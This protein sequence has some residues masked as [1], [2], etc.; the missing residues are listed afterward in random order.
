VIAAK[1]IVFDLDGVLADS[2]ALVDRAWET[3]AARHGVDPDRAVAIGRGRRA[4]EAIRIL[5]PHVD[6]SEG[7]IEMETL[8]EL[9]IESVVPIHGAPQFVQ[10]AI[11]AGTPWAVATSGTRRIAMPRLRRACIPEP[12]VLV[13]A[14]DITHGKPHPEPYEKAADALGFPPWECVV[15]E[16][17]PAGMLAARRSGAKVIGIGG[18]NEHT[19]A[20]CDEAALDFEDVAIEDG[21]PPHIRV[22]ASHYR[23]PCCA[24]HTLLGRKPIEACALCRWSESAQY[25]LAQAQA[26]VAEYGVIYRPADVRFAPARHPILGPRGEYAIDRVALRDRAYREFHAFGNGKGDRVHLTDRL[27]S[28]LGTVIN[29]DRL[30]VKT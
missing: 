27:R 13:T 6:P 25:Q 7:A 11:D 10:R 22:V 18:G 16:D 5:A 8:E 20:Y 29:A 17:A 12:P 15:F 23:C 14:D 24:C 30:Y 4:I 19:A 3:W 2:T 21:S 26:N 1:A 28:L 9:Q